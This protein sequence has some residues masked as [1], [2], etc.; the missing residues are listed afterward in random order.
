MCAAIVLGV[1][2]LWLTRSG[3]AAVAVFCV[4]TISLMPLGAEPGHPQELLVT[5]TALSIAVAASPLRLRVR[6]TLA[7]IRPRVSHEAQRRRLHRTGDSGDRAPAGKRHPKSRRG[8]HLRVSARAVDVRYVGQWACGRALACGAGIVVAVLMRPDTELRV[9]SFRNGASILAGLLLPIALI[10]IYIVAQGTTLTALLDGVVLRPLQIDSVYVLPLQLPP[11]AVA[12]SLV[13]AGIAV[14]ASHQR[15]AIPWHLQQV[16]PL[17]KV[18][19][20]LYVALGVLTP[21]E[22]IGG[23]GVI[24]LALLVPFRSSASPE[25]FGRAFLALSAALHTGTA[26]PA[27]GS[28]IAWSSFLLI[29]ASYVCLW[30]GLAA[31]RESVA[32]TPAFSRMAATGCLC[33]DWPFTITRASRSRWR[34]L[35]PHF[36][37]R[38]H[39][40]SRVQRRFA[41][42]IHRSRRTR[43]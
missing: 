14:H 31:L 38:P 21:S 3:L 5:L 2:G 37:T 27:A 16:L 13:A 9:S 19:V 12:A 6:V 43:G 33:L 22:I 35:Q 34:P 24:I 15:S 42:L 28:Q 8:A 39:Y 36:R 30:D 18:V 17:F 11:G 7:S 32:D 26:Y 25:S 29:L 23:S 20:G 10:L 4:T 41:S 1:A 40:P